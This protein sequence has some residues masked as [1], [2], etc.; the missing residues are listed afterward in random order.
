MPQIPLD[1]IYGRRRPFA[2]ELPP[3]PKTLTFSEKEVNFLKEHYLLRKQWYQ[4]AILIAMILAFF[5]GLGV[6]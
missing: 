2:E 4:L 3:N 6:K 1:Q 5:I